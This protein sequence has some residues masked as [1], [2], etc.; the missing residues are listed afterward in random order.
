LWG[1]ALVQTV[2]GTQY[3][4]TFTDDK[5]RW[6]WVS[7]L[8]HKNNA[9]AVFKEWLTFVEKETGCKLLIFRTDNGGEFLSKEW[10]KFLKDQGIR[11]ETTSPDTPE[12]N[13]DTECQNQSIFDHVRTVLIDTGLPLFLWAEATNYIVHT[14]N[15]NFTHALT[16]TIPYEV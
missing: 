8:K 4:I 12:Q 2:N 1:L 7:F 5:S 11:H 16:N 3:V 6:V 13:G 15:C 10:K 14:K 9:F